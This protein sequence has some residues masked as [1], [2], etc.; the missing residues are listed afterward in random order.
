MSVDQ[1]C[2]ISVQSSPAIGLGRR[3]SRIFR[4]GKSIVVPIDDSL[5]FGPTAGLDDVGAKVALISQAKPEAILAFP[6]VFKAYADALRNVSGIVNLTASTVHSGHTRKVVI[7]SVELALQLGADAVAV[8]VNVT[9]SYEYEMLKT[10]GA[11]VR[12]CEHLGMPLLAIMYPRREMPNGLDDNYEQL[13]LADQPAFT[14]LVAHAARIG[15]DL[16]ATIIKT[17]YTG[18]PDSFAHVVEACRPVPVVVAGGPV[19]PAIEMLQIASDVMRGG[20]AG[21]SFGRNVFG[22]DDP[23]PFIRALKAV[24]HEHSLPNIAAEYLD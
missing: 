24:V 21:I 7:G 3:L 4:D 23:R 5:I 2:D 18:T 15:V 8:H 20:G 11:V 16:G 1:V 6:G 14:R 9:S 10:L 22:K 13:Q 17:R 12:E 19:R